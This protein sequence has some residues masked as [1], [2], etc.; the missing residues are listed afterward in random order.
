MRQP[1]ERA[2]TDRLLG[3]AVTV[4][5]TLADDKD[6]GW[7]EETFPGFADAERMLRWIGPLTPGLAPFALRSLR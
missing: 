2:W 6:R 5:I 7:P 4:S 1:A 3:W